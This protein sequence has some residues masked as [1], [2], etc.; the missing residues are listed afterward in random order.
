MKGACIV[1]ITQRIRLHQHAG[2]DRSFEQIWMKRQQLTL[3]GRGASRKK[4]NAVIWLATISACAPAA[5]LEEA[6]RK[7]FGSR[8]DIFSLPICTSL[9]DQRRMC[10]WRAGWS[11]NGNRKAH[12]AMP[13]SRCT[14]ILIA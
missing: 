12:V 11:R 5:V 4:R 13:A 1:Q 7:S 8:I 9:A 2:V 6:F 10:A 3:L 14:N